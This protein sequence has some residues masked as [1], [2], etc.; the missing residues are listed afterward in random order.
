MS[1]KVD[2]MK[3]NATDDGNKQL[4]KNLQ[5]EI[6]DLE[7]RLTSKYK[8]ENLK[9]KQSLTGILSS[10]FQNEMSASKKALSSELSREYKLKLKKKFQIFNAILHF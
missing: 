9:M 4:I 6:R 1:M 2:E 5:I 8:S 10:R 3:K 7:S